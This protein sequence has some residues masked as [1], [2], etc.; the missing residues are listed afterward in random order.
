[1]LDCLPAAVL[2]IDGDNASQL[3]VRT[4]LARNVKL[5]DYTDLSPAALGRARRSATPAAKQELS[6]GLRAVRFGVRL[7]PRGPQDP[8]RT[9]N[10]P[11]QFARNVGKH[12]LHSY[13]AIQCLEQLLGLVHEQGFI[14]VNDYGQ[15]QLTPA[16]EFEHQRFS[17][18]TFVGVNFP[19]LRAYF[20]EGKALSLGRSL[21]G[22][23]GYSRS[24]AGTP[25]RRRH[26]AAFPGMFRQ[27][28]A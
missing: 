25:A 6:G 28:G 5:E 24:A 2:E 13:G 19:L 23:R 7:P 3:C 9:A 14:L 27:G 8:C 22:S 21:R 10:S 1:M 12:V 4:C 26:G 18:A 17:L 16:D 11:W 20:G 15:T